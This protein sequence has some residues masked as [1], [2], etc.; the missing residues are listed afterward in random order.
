MSRFMERLKSR[1]PFASKAEEAYY[2]LMRPLQLT[3]KYLSEFNLVIVSEEGEL[4]SR[5]ISLEEAKD[6]IAALQQYIDQFSQDSID[7]INSLADE[8]VLESLGSGSSRAFLE[9]WV[10][11]IHQCD[12]PFYKIGQTAGDVEK[13]L[14]TLSHQNPQGLRLIH[15]F[16]CQDRRKTEQHLHQVYAG[17]RVKGEWFELSL[18]EVTAICAMRGVE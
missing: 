1:K 2:M 15:K 4:G 13:R 11:L 7:K 5:A 12:S 10:Y 17:L 8:Q 9:G 3:F 18:D 16:Y 14:A 6:A